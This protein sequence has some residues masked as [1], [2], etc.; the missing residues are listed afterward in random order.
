MMCV[1]TPMTF[2]FERALA[3]LS[4]GFGNIFDRFECRAITYPAILY[5]R[6]FC[7]LITRGLCA[8]WRRPRRQPTD[9]VRGFDRTSRRTNAFASLRCRLT[10][11]LLGLPAGH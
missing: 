11:A 8:I 7:G 3:L 2:T 5:A 4:G 9:T 1:L 10:L 6:H